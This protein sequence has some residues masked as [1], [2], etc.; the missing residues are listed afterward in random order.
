MS[1]DSVH[2]LLLQAW[3]LPKDD[4]GEFPFL[5]EANAGAVVVALVGLALLLGGEIKLSLG[6]RDDHIAL[7]LAEGAAHRFWQCAAAVL[8]AEEA[9]PGLGAVSG[10]REDAS[11]EAQQQGQGRD[12]GGGATHAVGRFALCLGQLPDFFFKRKQIRANGSW[13]R[14]LRQLGAVPPRARGSR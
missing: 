14:L 4:Q 1:A 8:G 3:I 5:A 10:S 2:W 12:Q 7:A 9:A 13:L 6:H 11:R